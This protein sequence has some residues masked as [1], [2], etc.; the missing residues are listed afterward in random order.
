MSGD[1][2]QQSPPPRFRFASFAESRA[3]C[4]PREMRGT[5]IIRL[6]LFE[7]AI[8]ASDTRLADQRLK[9][10][11]SSVDHA[12]GCVPTEGF[13]WFIR[14][15]KRYQCGQSGGEHFEELRMSYSLAPFE[16]W[17]A[18]RRSPYVLAFYDALP[19]DLKESAL[20]ETVAIINLG[21]YQRG[22]EHSA[23]TWTIWDQ[24]RP[25]L[26]KTRLDYPDST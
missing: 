2:F 16:G 5:A 13:L 4:N 25:R 3:I 17:I 15:W 8:N 23:R 6:R 7:D 22:G 14:Y 11:R 18:F 9:S 26:Q 1:G 24:L 20:N 10:L 12:L 21:I 19:A